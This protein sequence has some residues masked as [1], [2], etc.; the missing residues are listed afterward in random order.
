MSEPLTFHL[1][2]KTV[3]DLINLQE[4]GQLNLNPSF[5]RDSVWKPLHRRRFVQT[6]L[7]GYPVP[8]IFLYHDDE[9]MYHVLDGKQRLETIFKFAKVS[10]VAKE[11]LQ[12][13]YKLPDDEAERWYDWKALGKAGKWPEFKA[14]R[15]QVVEVR[16]PMSDI[17]ELFVRINSTGTALTRSE[18]NNAKFYKTAFMKEA[19][20]LARNFRRYLEDSRIVLPAQVVR[21]K[22]IELLSELMASIANSG[23]INKKA[24]V[25]KAIQGDGLNGNTLGKIVRELT[26]TMNSVR[27]MFPDL[28][29]TRFH[30]ISE[31]Y[32]LFMVVYD[33]QQQKLVLTDS[34]RNRQ[35]QS[36]L[37]R[38]SNGVDDVR[39][40]QK[41]LK[42][43][44][45]D[46]MLYTRYLFSVQQGTD[47]LGQRKI[48]AESLQGLFAGLFE[49]KDEQRVFSPE[50]R[51]LLWNSEA[52]RYCPGKKCGHV[53]L[54]WGN[55]QIDHVKPHSRGGAT[56]LENAQILCEKCNKSKGAK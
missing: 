28:Y 7:D 10:G 49:K 53:K 6:I 31:F 11:V 55:L 40:R 50:Q 44:R 33:F 39:E 37:T 12:V 8:S 2:D 13:K 16:G 47:S 45:P 18:V 26:A 25:D 23:P 52:E 20:R 15:V 38:F 36:L 43:A 35:A 14:Y 30:N 3:T 54:T 27:K 1:T 41:K 19:R 17:V 21:M 32:S 34:K 5:Q 46:E 22:D 24:A 48:R 29:C 56:T 51:R 42:G 4:N 9:G